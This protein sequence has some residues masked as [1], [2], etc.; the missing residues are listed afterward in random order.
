MIRVG[1]NTRHLQQLSVLFNVRQFLHLLEKYS[2]L[3]LLC[4]ISCGRQEN[5][6]SPTSR[7]QTRPDLAQQLPITTNRCILQTFSS[8]SVLVQGTVQVSPQ[9]TYPLLHCHVMKVG[10]LRLRQSGTAPHECS[11]AAG[12]Y[13]IEATLPRTATQ[14]LI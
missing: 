11:Q 4:F 10:R 12:N 8:D 7:A 14:S 2:I 3:P 9:S 6:I 5:C 13:R 1:D